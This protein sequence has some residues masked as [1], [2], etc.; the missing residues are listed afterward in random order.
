MNRE[1][2]LENLV[3]LIGQEFNEDDVIIAFEDFE[4]S[5]E[6]NIIVENGDNSSYDKVAYIN[7]VDAT[8]FYFK[9]DEDGTINSV[10]YR[11]PTER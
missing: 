9:L 3:A 5:G 10:W 2:V 8:E 4:E 1:M 7:A 11:Y 6:T